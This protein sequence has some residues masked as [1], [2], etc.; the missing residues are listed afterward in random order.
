MSAA[1]STTKAAPAMTDPAALPNGQDPAPPLLR[2]EG[3]TKHF[4][5]GGALSRQKLH[6]VDDVSISIGERQVV[7]AGGESGS[8]K[9][10]IA[11]LRC[12]LYKPTGGEIHSQ[13]RPLSAIR[14]RQ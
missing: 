14:S 11:W 8:R 3:L 5:I 1:S 4:K 7:A 13:G 2:T 10:T 9:G 12:R 6:A